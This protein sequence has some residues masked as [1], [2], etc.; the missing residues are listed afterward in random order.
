MNKSKERCVNPSDLYKF[1]CLFFFLRLEMMVIDAYNDLT[2]RWV[3]AGAYKATPT[4]ELY[5]ESLMPPMPE[6]Y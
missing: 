5:S 1:I 3:A 2:S 6:T 4:E